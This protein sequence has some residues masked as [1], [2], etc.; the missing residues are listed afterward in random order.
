MENPE[1]VAPVPCTTAEECKEVEGMTSCGQVYKNEEIFTEM[2]K[3]CVEP[4]ACSVQDTK[5]EDIYEMRCDDG[6]VLRS[7]LYFTIATVSIYVSM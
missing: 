6:K 4:V 7:L 2:I 5:G 1:E 3:Q